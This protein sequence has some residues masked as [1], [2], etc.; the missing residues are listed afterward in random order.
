LTRP[1]QIAVEHQV[2]IMGPLN[3]AAQAPYHASQMYAHNIST[4]LGHL[5]GEQG[6]RY[7]LEDEITRQ[8]L[9]LRDGQIVHPRVLELMQAQGG[10]N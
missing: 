8:T 5:L 7:D 6:L 1:G 9:V 2:H 10:K 4:F 3:L